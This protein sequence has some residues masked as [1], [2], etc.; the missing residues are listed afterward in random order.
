LECRRPVV[1][2]TDEEKTMTRQ[3]CLALGVLV[4]TQAVVAQAGRGGVGAADG[5]AV[6]AAT[7][8]AQADSPSG[9][10]VFS[11]DFEGSF[12]GAWHVDRDAGS[13][14]TEWGKVTCNAA[15][16]SGSAWCAGGGAV[17]QA[18][19]TSYIDSMSTRM[20][21]GPFS[22]A[23]ALTAAADFDL[24]YDTEACCDAVSFGVSVD[25]ANFIWTD[26][27]GSSGGWVHE[28]I[29]LASLSG[30]TPVGAPQV[31]IA[32]RFTSDVGGYG[33]GAFVD[34]VVI[35]K[36]TTNDCS[37]TLSQTTANVPATGGTGSVDATVASGSGCS[38]T[39]TTNAPWIHL[40]SATS[41]S[42]NGT[43]SYSADANP[44]VARTGTIAFAGQLLAI[45][46]AASSAGIAVF[47][48]DFED[49][50]PG[51][52]QV[53]HAGGAVN[54]EWGKV[55]C[56]AS[57]G[58][59]SAWCAAGGTSPQP[60]CSHYI[61]SMSTR[62]IYGPFSLAD[63]IAAWAEFDMWYNTEDCCDFFSFGLSTDG[64]NFTWTDFSGNSGGWLHETID[65]ADIGGGDAVGAAQVWIA[66][67]FTSDVGR[68]G[69]GAFVDN[70]LVSKATSCGFDISEGPQS[71]TISSG[72]TATLSVT[73]SGASGLSYQWY[74]GSSGDTSQP[75]GTNSSSFTT[76]ALTATTSYWVRVFDQC[77]HVDSAT[78][79]VT[80][81]PWYTNT[82]WVP[83]ASHAAGLNQSQ[84]RTD[85]GLLN[86]TAGT[87]RVEGDYYGAGGVISNT[88]YV[89]PGTQSIL[90]DIVGQ[91]GG[92]GSGALRV[93][94]DQPLKITDR[95]Y[96]QVSSTAACYA[97]GT[98]G[99]D[100]PVVAAAN[101][102]T[103]GEAAYLAGL[104]E[105][106]SYHSNIALV[107]TGTTSA[108]VL[109]ELFDGA[110]NKLAQYTVTLSSGLWAQATQP[111]KS[112]AG[113]TAMDRGYAR[114]TV[115]SGS[116]VF[117]FA[118]VIS[119]VTNDP[120]T[121]TM[122]R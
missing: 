115:Q 53:D 79:T 104:I 120:T 25:G 40:T 11:D 8:V 34:N 108:T 67:R 87:A 42:G 94:S 74:E 75:V 23:D 44:G 55:T 72:G 19:C 9:I 35:S 14:D 99:Q 105:N 90:V 47:S 98:Q 103:A 43:L 15:S 73:V 109:V 37:F 91:L 112:K 70:V 62:M 122:L 6:V 86:T 114:I 88:T 2:S 32:F 38:W 39:A 49:A 61:D 106:A 69:G 41:G 10:V 50:F 68:T 102:L 22:L 77:G 64:S 58:T 16:G 4:A 36:T 63:A 54:T 51:S 28:T 3:A 85:L 66:F 27:A 92:S 84:W 17:P 57:S 12:P 80:V 118:S 111:F 29:D 18:A 81:L 107:N 65:F 30:I 46:Q 26:Y 56:K 117:G 93:L 113:Q 7:T 33:A 76:P 83:V 13:A 52:W 59:G 60:A 48:D 5:G 1:D 119:N 31:W 20:V 101:G 96:N 100:Y 78:A 116:G 21:A 82:A 71:T 110:G 95:T 24:S 121:V 89:P 45:N 97:N